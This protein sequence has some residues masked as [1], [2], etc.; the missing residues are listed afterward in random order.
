MADSN[1]K[2]SPELKKEVAQKAL[3][4]NKK[5][6]EPLSEEYGVP[7]SLILTWAVALEKDNSVFDQLADNADKEEE[8]ETVDLKIN[9]QDIQQSVL[10]GVMSDDLN[11]RRLVS[12]SVIGVIIITIF[13][14]M[15]IESY[16]V[17]IGKMPEQIAGEQAFYK[18]THKKNQATKELNSFGV[19]DEEKGIYRVP[20]D[21]VME[22]M[23]EKTAP[24]TTQKELLDKIDPT[25]IE[26]N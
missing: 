18:V 20:V 25:P 24:D 3:S 17:G 12:W 15:L 4:R 14:Q 10:Q 1:D 11:Y 2:Y 9:N 26:N 21:M 7:T 19:V 16:E 23:A 8:V 22:Q 6:L 5:R 13:A